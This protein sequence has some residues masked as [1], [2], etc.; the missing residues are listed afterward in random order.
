MNTFHDWL[1]VK[2]FE[3]KDFDWIYLIKRIIPIREQV[4]NLFTKI[5]KRSIGDILKSIIIYESVHHHNTEK[6][7]K[8]IS[9]E[10]NAE[11]INVRNMKIDDLKNYDLVGFGSGIY[12]GK[13]HKNMKKF[14]KTIE[15][16][17]QQKSFVFTTSGRA[18]DGFT[19]KFK[20][21]LISKGFDVISSF[22]C[23]GFDTFGPLKLIGGINKGKPNEED[24]ANAQNFA[25]SLI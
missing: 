11:L 24:I 16:V 10:I 21:L 14:I 3:F 5:K 8:T 13:I 19:E 4:I 18:K 22:S 2:L 17:N 7:A 12:Y 1:K 25:N 9:N 15:N 6:I 23:K 20:E